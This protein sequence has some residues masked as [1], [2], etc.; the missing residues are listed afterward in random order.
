MPPPQV[1]IIVVRAAAVPL[2][3]EASGR[4]A[5]TRASDVRARVA[6]V[7]QKRLYEEGSMVE[8]GQPLFQID[9]APLRA[10][11]AAANAGLEQ[12]EAAATNARVLAAR[13]RELAQQALI[14]RMQLDDAEAQERSTAAQVSMAKA[15]VQTARINLSYANVTAPISGR[16]GQARVL[17][18][19]LVG[20]GEATLL[21]VVEQVDPMF[22]FFDQ[23][24]SD[25]VRLMRAQAEG[26]VTLAEGKKAKVEI[27]RAD[28]TPYPHPGALDFSAYSVDPTTGSVAFRGVVPNPDRE[29]LPGMYVNVRLT[30]GQLNKGYRVPQKAVQRDGQGAFVLVADAEG[31]VAQKRV[32]T[33]SVV[34][35]DWVIS[36]G[37]ADG[38]RVI[39]S[40]VQK[41][42]PGAKVNAVVASA[43]PQ[44]P[45][46]PNTPPSGTEAAAPTPAAG[47]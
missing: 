29:L 9:P 18:G 8:Q 25:F 33:V 43:E 19:A 35:S 31:T 26:F 10:A 30:A 3:R 24:G 38:D 40:G 36:G 12:A 4:L 42:Q 41:A 27:I 1:G 23:P 13:N 32:D 7:L 47:S 15:Q 11:L 44:A 17:E 5:P 45:A 2:I 22:V 37:L 6:G 16:A 14:S 21:T 20:Q 34:G 39:V 46:P 28:G